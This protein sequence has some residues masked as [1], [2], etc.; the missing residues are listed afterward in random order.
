MTDTGC[1]QCEADTYSGDAATEC[2]PC[3]GGMKSDPGSKSQF[4]CYFG[5]VASFL[6]KYNYKNKY[7][8]NPA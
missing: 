7:E 4:D 2:I 3:S 8:N 1:Q 5:K 6:V